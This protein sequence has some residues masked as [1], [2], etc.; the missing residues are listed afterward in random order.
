MFTGY[1][2][3]C[4]TRRVSYW[5]IV[6]S[7]RVNTTRKHGL[8]TR[9]AFKGVHTTRQASFDHPWIRSVLTKTLSFNA[10]CQN[11]PST[12]VVGHGPS[13]R[14]AFTNIVKRWILY[15]R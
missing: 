14:P 10:F 1:E 2:H 5:T 9:V 12:S 6:F 15:S 13:T 11:G 3:G 7:D 4:P 8:L